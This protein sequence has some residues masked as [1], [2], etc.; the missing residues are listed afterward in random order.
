MPFLCWHPADQ[1]IVASGRYT[2]PLIITKSGTAEEPISII[3][4]GRPLIETETESAAILI[5]GSYVEISGFEAHA[6]GVGFC[7]RGGQ[8]K[9]SRA[10]CR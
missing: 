3:G 2:E 5:S 1:L 8:A 6:L 7:N 4:D 9:P 10:S